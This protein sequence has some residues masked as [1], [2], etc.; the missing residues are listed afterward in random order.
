MS[1]FF[2]A[3]NFRPAAA[4]LPLRPVP[5]FPQILLIFIRTYLPIKNL[6]TMKNFTPLLIFNRMMLLS[7]AM[8]LCALPVLG[9][10]LEGDYTINSAE[11]TENTNFQSFN[12]FADAL[13]D[14]GISGNVTATI[15]IGSGPYN[16][17][18]E[19]AGISG[20][21]PDAVLVIEGNGETLTAATN[22]DDR[23]VLRLTDMSHVHINNLHLE[24]DTASTSGFY[25]IHIYSSGSNITIS[26][27][28]ADIA[29]TT[30]T[31]TGAFIGSGDETSILAAGDFNNIHILD[32][33]V[34]GGGYGASVYGEA[35]NLSTNIVIDGN[36]FENFN[37]NGVYLRE[38]DGTVVSNNHFDRN[39]GNVSS[40]NAIQ[41]AQ[42]ENINA[43]IFNNI[44]EH[45]QTANGN[46]TFR[47]IY[48][49]NGAGH[50]VYN[51]VIHN[52]QLE[53]GDVTGIE[54]RTAGSAPEIY[55]NTIAF[56]DTASTSGELFGF[57]ESLSNTNSILR[58]NNI[59]ITQPTVTNATALVLGTTTTPSDFDSDY[60][61]LYVP[62]GNVAQ[63]GTFTPSFYPSLAVWQS[64]SGQ[65]DNSFD[66]DPEFLAE[67]ISIPT[68]SEMNDL[69]IAI[70]EIDE[71][72]LGYNRNDPPDVG[73]YEFE[74]CDLLL[75]GDI[76][77]PST[78]CDDEIVFYS[79]DPVVGASDYHWDIEGDANIVDGSGTTEISV[80]FGDENVTISVAT[81]DSCGIGPA[82]ELE[83]E[84]LSL[85]DSILIEGL[86]EVCSSDSGF[87]YSAIGGPG[88]SFD[89]Q[90]D[91]GAEVISGQGS[92]NVEILFGDSTAT[93]TLIPENQCGV[94]DTTT[95]TININPTPEVDLELTTEIVCYDAPGY[96]LI[97]GTPVG[98]IY[99][100]QGVI[101]NQ[102]LASAAGVGEHTITYIY[103]D[104][105]GCAD[106]AQ[107]ELE[108]AICPGIDEENNV[109][110]KMNVFP[111]PFHNNL[112][113]QIESEV[114][115][116]AD[117]F[118]FD[119]SGK[120][121]LQDAMTIASSNQMLILPVEH[122]AA[123]NYVLSLI[124]ED[125]QLQREIVKDR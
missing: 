125:F 108:V 52:I 81:E 65:D 84:V 124:H 45:T 112:H 6:N 115:G 105:L 53:S 57:T 118:I 70:P 91:G 74:G 106:S 77:G 56:T 17:Q 62:D 123:G 76:E 107:A 32:N 42:N 29:G 102:F 94:G 68:S 43:E 34:N 83:V 88:M 48:L 11:A 85:P 96:E 7:G 23:H 61:N 78:V 21:S 69:G 37:S 114:T 82:S 103:T 2:C 49:F 80:E 44:I 40:C 58:N 30:S 64:T 18:I 92:D 41:V 36:N 113:L 122:L 79:I 116:P 15:T 66:I 3:H 98:G 72:I 20:S 100:G 89:W 31:L 9:Q 50:R 90:V 67:D 86:T 35:D 55:F 110:A 97:G 46:L 95:V 12:D 121:V 73:A 26:N 47:G 13:A 8:L 38:T 119:L 101:S 33:D 111:N 93:I 104:S 117:V 59:V 28:T 27:C 5:A 22:T 109:V 60:N 87:F 19:F 71:D 1:R 63:A 4:D 25:G 16:E 54:V 120:V 39:A 75:A 51:N 14:E 24:R 99:F 10:P